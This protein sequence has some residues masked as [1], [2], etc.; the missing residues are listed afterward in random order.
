MSFHDAPIFS[1]G[2]GPDIYQSVAKYTACQVTAAPE[3][4]RFNATI[5][6]RGLIRWMYPWEYSCHSLIEI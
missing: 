5:K 6:S 1:V 3:H 4:I 2:F